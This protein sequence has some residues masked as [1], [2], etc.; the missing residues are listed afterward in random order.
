M[1]YAELAIWFLLTATYDQGYR[2]VVCYKQNV[3][4]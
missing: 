2:F 4:V 1:Y 3:K